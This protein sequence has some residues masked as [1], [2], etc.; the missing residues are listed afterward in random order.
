VNAHSDANPTGEVRGQIGQRVLVGDASGAQEV[1]A[2]ASTASG[3]AFVT[4]DQTTRQM[5]GS[6][7]LQG[8]TATVAHIHMAAAGTNG[9]VVFD[10]AET[11][12]GSG[13]WA[14]PSGTVLN[15]EQAAALL[16]GEMYFNVHSAAFSAG[17]IR[18]QLSAR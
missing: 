16:A 8:M 5:Q 13:V 4:Y 11:A 3:R 15:A 2:N 12:T 18:A 1:P 10:L 7:T 9:P 6:I 17:E 14:L